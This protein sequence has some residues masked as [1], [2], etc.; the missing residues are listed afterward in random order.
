MDRRTSNGLLLSK[1]GPY[2]LWGM[3]GL[4]KHAL[5]DVF[6]KRRKLRKI[7]KQ[8]TWIVDL[9]GVLG[10]FLFS[11]RDFPEYATRVY[12]HAEPQQKIPV[13]IFDS[14]IINTAPRLSPHLPISSSTLTL[15]RVSVHSDTRTT[16]TSPHFRFR[17]TN[18]PSHPSTVSAVVKIAFIDITCLLAAASMTTGCHPVN[19]YLGP[20]NQHR[21]TLF[22]HPSCSPFPLKNGTDF[23]HGCEQKPLTHLRKETKNPKKEQEKRQQSTPSCQI[24]IGICA[25]WQDHVRDWTWKTNNCWRSCMSE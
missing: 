4:K 16:S 17:N 19:L 23:N 3:F 24:V 20:D 7:G 6:H 25:P 10:N 14:T 9:H 11:F 22:C 13:W 12:R 5:L 15:G 18:D 21:I 2:G 1:L 8:P